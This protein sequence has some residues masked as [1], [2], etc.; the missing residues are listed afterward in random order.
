M[1][2]KE[3]LFMNRST[4]RIRI[5]PAALL[6]VSLLIAALSG[7]GAGGSTNN[8]QYA[9]TTAAA[10]T[11]ARANAPQIAYD[12]YEYDMREGEKMAGGAIYGGDA[13]FEGSA[14]ALNSP[15]ENPEDGSASYADSGQEQVRKLIKNVNCGLIVKDVPAVYQRVAEIT[16]SL[17]GY[18]FSK[19]ESQRGGYVYYS[20]TIKL[21]P[22]NLDE[23]ERQ[24][25][26]AAGENAVNYYNVFSD[27]IT[28]EYYDVTARLD[29]MRASM[30]QYLALI[31]KARNVTEMLEIRREITTL[32]AEIDGLQGQINVWNMLVGLA[33]INLTIE[34][35]QDPLSQTRNQ[36][37]SFNT[38]SEIINAMGN[39]FIATGN[40]LYQF[41]IGFFVVIVSLLPVLIP[42]GI[43]VFIVFRIRRKRKAKKI[44]AAD[45]GGR[46]KKAPAGERSELPSNTAQPGAQDPNQN[47]YAKNEPDNDDP[48]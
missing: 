28:S 42:L 30:V 19:S 10:A 23:F 16:N 22:E 35:E 12:S 39:G 14:T 40:A 26:A 48:I 43:L 2:R 13:G 15:K 33:T 45:N 37:W 41:V 9:E 27:D 1:K 29:S 6:L 46:R 20:L 18:E 21:P 3:L 24:I 44:N 25:R 7:C 11:M 8:A 17:G 38:P 5:L 47:G 36:Q 31:E 34:R 32:Q 4:A